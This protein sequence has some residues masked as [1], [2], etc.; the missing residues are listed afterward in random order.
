MNM[1]LQEKRILSKKKDFS[2]WAVFLAIALVSTII[3]AIAIGSTYIEPGVV[4]KVLINK[5]ELLSH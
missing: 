5:C 3:G 1:D 2:F 4:Y